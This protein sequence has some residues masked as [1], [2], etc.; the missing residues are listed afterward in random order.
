[1]ETHLG[2]AYAKLDISSRADLPA[3]LQ[4]SEEE[5]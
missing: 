5:V 2:N 1:V 4:P 3:A